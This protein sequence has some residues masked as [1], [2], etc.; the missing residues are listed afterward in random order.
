MRRLDLYLG[1]TVGLTI[2]MA[3]L[4]LVGI[5]GI[6]T[7]LEQIEDIRHNYTTAAV[8]LYVLQSVPRM[9]YE[10]I[11]Y[12]ALIGCL[13]GLG[14]LANNSE[15]VVMRAAGISTWSIAFSAMK[16]AFLLVLGGFICRRI[17]SA[18]RRAGCSGQSR[19]SH[20]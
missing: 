13:A 12:A 10:T 1:G 7:F 9:F 17:Y 5:L 16:P 8:F 15:L 18:G 2:V 6:F 11:P 3:S 4:G 14:T 20:V 19:A